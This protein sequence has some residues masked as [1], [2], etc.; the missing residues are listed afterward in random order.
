[1]HTFVIIFVQVHCLNP[2]VLWSLDNTPILELF[3]L[4]LYLQIYHFVVYTKVECSATESCMMR[5]G[6]MN[7]F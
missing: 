2:G 1:M 4:L 6:R 5:L 3:I 7:H